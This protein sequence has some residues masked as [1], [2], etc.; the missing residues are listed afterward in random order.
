MSPIRI[1]QAIIEFENRL[2]EDESF[3]KRV[4]KLEKDFFF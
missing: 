4:R 2:R 3:R 1:S